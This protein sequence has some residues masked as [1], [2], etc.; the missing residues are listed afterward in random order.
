MHTPFI[1]L[2]HPHRWV[3]ALL[4]MLIGAPALLPSVAAAAPQ[5]GQPAPDFTSADSKGASVSLS[6]YRGKTVVL[7]WTNADCPYTRKHYTSGNM[8]GV[9]ALAQK[10]GVVWLTVISSA[11]GKQGYVNGPAADA[12]T[13]SRAALPTAVLL[14][15][16]GTV[17]RMYGAKTTPHMFVID[18]NGTL[19]YMGGI[20]SIATAEVDDIPKAEPYLKEAMLAVAQ[21]APVAHSVTKPYGCSI[22]Y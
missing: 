7:E 8:Q 22:K 19:Q 18:K 10:N 15:P 2:H 13:T 3:A 4:A 9:Q 17:G 16:S 6:Q 1:T 20:D 21:G 14:D 11:P 5:I 12:L